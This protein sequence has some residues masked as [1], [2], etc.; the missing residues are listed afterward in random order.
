MWYY[1]ISIILFSFFL[2]FHE[3]HRVVPL[4]QTCSTFE[5]V[6]DHVCFCV[7][8]Y[9]W[10]YLPHMRENMRLL[11]FWSWL[12]SFNMMSS[13][14]IYLPSNLMSLFLVGM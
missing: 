3:F 11:C 10:I 14:C 1:W 2:S 5:F 6:Y 8:V 9:L 12:I 4:L 7:Y 13:N